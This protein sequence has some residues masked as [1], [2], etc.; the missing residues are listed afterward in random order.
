MNSV[1][2]IAILAGLVTFSSAAYAA[3]TMVIDGATVHPITKDPFVGRVVIANGIIT[4]VGADVAI[5]PDAQRIDAA[6]LHVYP[7]LFDAFS[8]LGLVEVDA[9]SATNDHTEM[10]MYNPHLLA[11]TAIHPSS[12]VLPVTRA[13][14]ITHAIVAPRAGRDGVISGQAAL[15][16]LD[17]WTV[18][19]MAVEPSLA[20]V[21]DWPG[22]V[23]RRYDPVTFSFKDTPYN[24]AKEAAEKEQNELREWFD[25][26]RHY[27]Q[28]DGVKDSRAQRD[29]KLAALSLC[30]E[31]KKPVII[32]AE[33]K[34]DIEAAVAFAEEYQLNMILAGAADAWRVKELLAKKNIPVILR[35]TQSLPREEDDSYDQP[36]ATPAQLREAGIRIAF[37]SSAGS[38]GGAPSGPHG[39]RTVP[40][41]A[42][43]ATGYGLS[44]D[45]ALRAVTLWPAEIFG[46][47]D[48]LGSIEAGKIANLIVTDGSPLAIE[49]QLRHLVIAGRV[50]ELGNKHASLYEKYRARPHREPSGAVGARR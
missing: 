10:G 40:Y 3:D 29:Q 5:P 34:R 13:N 6:G 17:G 36:Y 15:V 4:A 27:Q 32:V 23:T 42:E 46:V 44:E 41:E 22:I 9:V 49:S 16:N 30:L 48:R 24:D 21:I 39:S 18:A 47:A 25:A 12:E 7:G 19:E 31:G 28:A 33:A 11:A 38:G 50:V 2:R 43:Q 1:A 8:S 26:A 35:R 37:A 45:D 14:G 20:M